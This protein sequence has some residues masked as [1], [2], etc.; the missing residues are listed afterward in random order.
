MSIF[1]GIMK[2][3][4]FIFL[5]L[6]PALYS[7]NDEEESTMMEERKGAEQEVQPWKPV[8]PQRPQ[9][10]DTNENGYGQE[11]LR[12][13]KKKE[14]AT[15]RISEAAKELKMLEEEEMKRQKK[16]VDLQRKETL[17]VLKEKKE[18]EKKQEVLKAESM[19]DLRKK[20]KGFFR[21]LRRGKRSSSKEYETAQGI[22]ETRK[23]YHSVG[24]GFEGEMLAELKKLNEMKKEFNA[25]RLSLHTPTPPIAIP[26]PSHPQED[27]SPPE[28]NYLEWR[29]NAMAD[30]ETNSFKPSSWPPD[31]QSN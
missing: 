30:Y 9:K 13:K 31:N 3:I 11:T 29:S 27:P 17:R 20:P 4:P 28:K 5:L 12:I 26:S 23:R 8:R 2:Y 21:R 10:S 18:E 19:P 6:S 22:D 15:L 14:E 7:V 24:E 25:L 16:K 1:G